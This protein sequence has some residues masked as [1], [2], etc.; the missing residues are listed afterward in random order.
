MAEAAA[1][2]L[3]SPPSGRSLGNP[4]EAVVSGLRGRE[5]WLFILRSKNPAKVISHKA[6][7]TTIKFLDILAMLDFHIQR[8]H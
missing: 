6:L 8:I 2:R 1:L 5:G 3:E 7:Q 4:E